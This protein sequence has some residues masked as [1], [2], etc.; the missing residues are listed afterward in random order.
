MPRATIENYALSACVGG[1]KG[2]WLVA[3]GFLAAVLGCDA[4]A[5]QDSLGDSSMAPDIGIS[6]DSGLDELE[7]EVS[8]VSEARSGLAP[9]FILSDGLKR[10]ALSTILR[11]E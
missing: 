11:I 1:R 4:N 3:F 2:F 5:S 10:L 7:L 9:F 8:R 6:R